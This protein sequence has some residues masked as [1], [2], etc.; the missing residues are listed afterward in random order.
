MT[1][2][3]AFAPGTYTAVIDHI[4]DGLAAVFFEQGGEEVGDTT[5]AASLLP[6]DGRHADARLSVSVGSTS[7]G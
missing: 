5:V 6:E 7:V 2:A 3:D 4:G 1:E